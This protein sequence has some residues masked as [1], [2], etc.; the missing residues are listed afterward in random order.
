MHYTQHT[1]EGKQLLYTAQK[2]VRQMHS[3]I[4]SADSLP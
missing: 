3:Y 4:T 2:N 1:M